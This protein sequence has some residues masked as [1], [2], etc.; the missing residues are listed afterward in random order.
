M[1]T[2]GET[3]D[4]IIRNQLYHCPDIKLR[5]TLYRTLGDRVDTISEDDLLREIETLAVL[6]EDEFSSK[7][8][9]D[10][11][12]S[13]VTWGM[14][15]MLDREEILKK[16]AAQVELEKTNQLQVDTDKFVATRGKEHHHQVLLDR[17]SI[18]AKSSHRE[19][20]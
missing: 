19:K 18:N 6:G 5:E 20:G 13:T 3:N 17:I 16:L 8:G 15:L 9:V 4:V 12:K 14:Q 10:A 1:K 7:V 2:S 11:N